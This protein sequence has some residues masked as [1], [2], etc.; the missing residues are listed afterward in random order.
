ML[1]NVFSEASLDL[2]NDEPYL[3]FTKDREQEEEEKIEQSTDSLGKRTR[4]VNIIKPP[5]G[6]KKTK[7]IHSFYKKVDFI[8]SK[9]Q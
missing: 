9:I 8:K 6:S 2:D 3:L 5:L 7:G 1:K 4:S